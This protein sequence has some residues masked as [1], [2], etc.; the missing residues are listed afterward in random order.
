[1]MKTISMIVISLV[2]MCAL[3]LTVSADETYEYKLD[4]PSDK[5]AE[6]AV[7]S[8]IESLPDEIKDALP[9][10]G[11][12]A[13]TGDYDT[14]Y[15]VDRI[16]SALTDAVSPAMKT[17]SRL[18]GIV[19]IGAVF[20]IY[21]ESVTQ[22]GVRNVFSF[23]STLCISLALFEVMKT[24]FNVTEALLGTLSKTMLAMIPAMEA[25]YISSGNITT[26][27]VTSTGVNLMIGFVQSVFSNVVSPALYTAFVLCLGASVTGNRGVAFI[28]KTLKGLIT[29]SVI[30]IMTVM[31]F[32]LSIQTAGASA[33][34][35]LTSKTVRFA[36]GSYLPIVGGSVAESFSLLSGSIGVIK[37]G[38]GITGIVVMIIAFL[39]PFAVILMNRIAVGFSGAVAGVLG[40]TEESTLL[41]ECKGICTI[42][43]A[44]CA[45][46]CVMY[47]IALG[48]FC[49]T[50]MAV[51]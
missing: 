41:E 51:R 4:R 20:H 38:C 47:V 21:A 24:L 34:D 50:P 25:I 29:G 15:F 1:M 26:A 45:G 37:Q 5:K 48:I 30:V 19:L 44:V 36:I 6:D 8:F 33:A 18:L 42:L 13:D 43:I 17:V 22:A 23:C 28:V 40:C 35:T 39:P 3:T 2:I 9:D 31:T 27:A 10:G 46:A 16:K 32:V 11:K 49:K 12:D 14:D 7:T